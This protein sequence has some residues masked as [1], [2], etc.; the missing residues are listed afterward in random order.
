MAHTRH[1]CGLSGGK[2]STALAIYMRDR[3][4]DMEYVFCDTGC[5]LEETYEYL[6]RLEAMLGVKLVR[7]NALDMLGVQK[8]PGRTPFDWVLNEM[9]GGY[10]PSPRSRW[11]TRILKIEP[12]ERHVGS[13]HAYSYI[14]IRDDE[15]RDGYVSKKPPTISSRPNILPV[16]PFKDDHL[17]LVDIK[18]I[19]EDSG[20][21]MP[22][23][24]RWRSRSGCYF[25]FYQQIGEWQGL[26]REHPDL[27]E[28]AKTY[29]RTS[30]KVFTWDD[31]RSL[32]ELERIERTFPLPQIDSAEGCAVCHL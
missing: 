10:L 5:E 4:T 2:D 6:E 29:E 28:K 27:F 1:I 19:L 22:E 32:D 8:K 15:D 17:T 25:C 16:Y 13:G 9:Y 30:G 14:G 11:C 18:R 26:R 31:C 20:L 3:V 7:L 24:Y 23:Y 12:F 21:G